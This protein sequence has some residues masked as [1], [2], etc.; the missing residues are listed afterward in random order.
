MSLTLCISKIFYVYRR[1]S[2]EKV[3]FNIPNGGK[4]YNFLYSLINS[5]G[6]ELYHYHDISMERKGNPIQPVVFIPG[7]GG[8]YSHGRFIASMV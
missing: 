5:Y 2:Y 1:P 4:E 6:Y 3:Y 7:H 8:I